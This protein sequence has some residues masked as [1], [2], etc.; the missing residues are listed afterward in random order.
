LV[1]SQCFWEVHNGCSTLFWD[2]TWEQ[3]PILGDEVKYQILHLSMERVDWVKLHHYWTTNQASCNPFIRTWKPLEEWPIQWNEQT[4]DM[5]S[6]IL[7]ER[8][9]EVRDGEDIIRWGR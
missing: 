2:D 8:Q 4:K 3:H 6:R 1:Q 9:V 7:Q 5:A